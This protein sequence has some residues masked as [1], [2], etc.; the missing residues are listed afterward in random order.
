LVEDE[1]VGLLEI[2]IDEVLLAGINQGVDEIEVYSYFCVFLP[3]HRDALRRGASCAW[4]KRVV[5]AWLD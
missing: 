3:E 1:I 4:E 2:Q 5:C